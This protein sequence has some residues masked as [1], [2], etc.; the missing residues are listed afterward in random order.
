MSSIARS[1]AIL[2]LFRPD[3]PALSAHEIAAEMGT[4]LSTVYRDIGHLRELGLIEGYAGERFILGG[5]IAVMD[6][7]ARLSDPLRA[8]A[9]PEMQ[10][11]SAATGLTVTM[12]RLYGDRLLGVDHVLGD[13]RISIGYERG[14]LVPLFRGCS[15]KVILS[16][17]PWRRLKAMHTAS[18]DEIATAGLGT[19]WATFLATVRGYAQLPALWTSGEI[20]PGNTGVAVPLRAGDNGIMASITVILRTDALA[21]LDVAELE[22][23]LVSA[24]DRALSRVGI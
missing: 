6:R 3:R 12:T 11:L 18:A 5:G 16:V 1:L 10:A 21:G 15:G 7:T 22:A 13:R 2:H 8:A 4:T 24:R 17:L 23:A 19:D 9:F 14:E 20:I